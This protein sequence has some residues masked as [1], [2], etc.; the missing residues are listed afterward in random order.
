[1]QVSVEATGNLERRMTVRVPE[2]RVNAEVQNRLERLARTTRLK[3]FR[4]GKVPLKVIEQ[5]YGAQVRQEVIGEVVQSTW[6]EA[7]T[8]EKLRPAGAPRIE[9]MGAEPGQALEYVATFEVLPEVK[10]ASLEGVKIER[11]TARVSDAEVERVVE[12]LR[13]QRTNW[14]AVER[15]AANGDRIVI[16]FVGTIDGQPFKGNEGENIPVVLGTGSMTPGFEEALVGVRG[17]EERTVEVTFPGEYGNK[18]IAGKRASFKVSV[19]RVEE[20]H[21][22]Q[23]DE[24]FAEGFGIREGGVPALMAEVRKNM[25][26]ELDEALRAANKQAAMDKLLE[27]NQVEVPKALVESE[28]RA[29]MEQMRRNMHVPRGKQFDIDTSMFEPQARRRVALGLILAEII[30]R[31]DF[32]AD[33]E[34]VRERVETLAGTYERPDEVMNWYYSDK[35]RLKE[36]ESLVLEEQVVDWVFGKAEVAE[37]ER[38]FDEVMNPGRTAHV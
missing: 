21:L 23:V 32:K 2:D 5:Q 19:H 1:M 3:G 7:V 22:P 26:R 28:V 27:L 25:E 33:P 38:G 6:Y 16:D 9:A 14:E 8:Q 4:P 24:A 31:N 37:K 17:G 30:K 12:N 29:L 11:V 35:S 10:L 15:V 13:R 18:E 36:V 20:P 34:R